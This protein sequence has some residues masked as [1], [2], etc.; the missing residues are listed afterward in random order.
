MHPMRL[1]PPARLAGAE[2]MA[3]DEA[4]LHSAADAG[5]ASLRFYTWAA[6]TLS[7]GY[8]QPAA[9]RHDLP[10]LP[11]VR[12]A[13]G[14]A[15]LVHHHELTVAV[16]LPADRAWQPAGESWICR[17]HYWVQE[18]LADLG[19]A[20]DAVACGRERKFGDV[21]CFEHQTAGDLVSGGAKVVGSAQRKLRG[22]L[23]QH[24]GILLRRSEFTP[25]LPGVF[26]LT[27]REVSAGELA[28]RLTAKFAAAFTLT[29]GDWTADEVTRRE[30]LVA[31][32]YGNAAWNEKR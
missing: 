5:V 21:L 24:G 2:Q 4:M 19:A 15:A 8:F 10:P 29:P 27:G 13:T 6:P 23:L 30:T 31:E 26:E 16:A 17:V 7:L 18:C 14:G 28:D 22:A 1:L 11:W 25:T 20:A 9:A 3:A 32:R 12:R